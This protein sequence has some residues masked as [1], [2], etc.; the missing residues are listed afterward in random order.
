MRKWPNISETIIRNGQRDWL[1]M[2]RIGDEQGVLWWGGSD[3][4][5][6]EGDTW[7]KSW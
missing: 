3:K 2:I 5:W 1:C 4:R 6:K 7:I